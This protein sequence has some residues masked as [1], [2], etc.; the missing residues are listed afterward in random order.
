MGFE[1][2]VSGVECNSLMRSL[3]ALAPPLPV[4]SSF[5][6]LWAVSCFVHPFTMLGT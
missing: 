1:I 4:S 3:G 2:Q 5:N 6:L